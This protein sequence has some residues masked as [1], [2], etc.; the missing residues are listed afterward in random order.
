M[1]NNQC[2]GTC[3]RDTCASNL[4]A[5]LWLLTLARIVWN[6]HIRFLGVLGATLKGGSWISLLDPT[7][8]LDG[9]RTAN[10]C[11]PPTFPWIRHLNL[12]PRW[13]RWQTT[14][15]K[16]H[17]WLALVSQHCSLIQGKVGG[18]QVLA[19]L[20]PSSQT[21]GSNKETQEAPTMRARCIIAKAMRACVT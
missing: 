18:I 14:T 10:T 15:L 19:S 3:P 16:M 13:L 8:W 11:I 2:N 17:N 7:V 12:C 4:P 6:N 5:F 20:A 21:V 1:Q 9:A